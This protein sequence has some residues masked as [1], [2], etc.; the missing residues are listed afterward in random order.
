MATTRIHVAAPPD[1]V[2]AVLADAWS[3]EQWV[4]GCKQ[5]RE[6]EEAWP[7]AGATFHHSV[8]MGPI[9][10]RDTTTAIESEAPRR[11]VMRARARPAGVARV[12]LDLAERD[13][14]TEVVM[15]ERPVS[16][17]PA[18]LHNPVQDWLIDRRNREGLR[19]LK[20]LAEQPA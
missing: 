3:Y 6:V 15:R 4:V 14:G 12:E 13:G 11:L 8:G 1:R 5:I 2:F 17:P 7:A 16:G 18:L 9:T 20:Q 19:R 10:V